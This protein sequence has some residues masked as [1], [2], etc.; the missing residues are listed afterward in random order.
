MLVSPS[1]FRCKN[2]CAAHTVEL[3]LCR[4]C[5]RAYR[6]TAVHKSGANFPKH[7]MPVEGTEAWEMY[8]RIIIERRREELERRLSQ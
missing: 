2:G 1:G 3:G 6:L 4:R 8:R 7:W 5:Y